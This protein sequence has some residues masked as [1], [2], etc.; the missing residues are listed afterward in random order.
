LRH[1]RNYSISQGKGFLVRIAQYGELGKHGAIFRNSI[2]QNLI[3]GR[4]Y[5]ADSRSEHGN[6]STFRGKGRFVRCGIDSASQT[7]DNA[8]SGAGELEA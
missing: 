5:I 2:R 3:L 7:T 8:E 4:I 6:C 1:S